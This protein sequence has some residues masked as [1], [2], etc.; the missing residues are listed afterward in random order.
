[1]GSRFQV[2]VL[3]ACLSATLVE[4][5][6]NGVAVTYNIAMDQ[7][8]Y[9]IATP[10]PPDRAFAMHRPVVPLN[11]GA[12]VEESYGLKAL[13]VH[14]T[15]QRGLF[16]GVAGAIE[17]KVFVR[18]AGPENDVTSEAGIKRELVAHFKREFTNVGYLGDPVPSQQ[19]TINGSSWLR[20]NEP[21]LG[22]VEYSTGLTAT[23]Y[24]SVQ[25]L[26]IDNTG[27]VS[28]AW[29]REASALMEQLLASM[30]IE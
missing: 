11:D 9:S 7:F 16:R 6:E 14:W 28:P 27:E 12:L 8:S 2:I 5:K 3:I 18:A 30:R 21:V 15:F 26:F 19:V 25:F 4:A 24:L 1:M 22:T 20:Y 10:V 13:N 23:R 29:F 17:L